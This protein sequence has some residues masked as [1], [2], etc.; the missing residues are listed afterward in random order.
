MCYSGLPGELPQHK[1]CHNMAGLT[2]TIH[3]VE[4]R[5]TIMLEAKCMIIIPVTISMFMHSCLFQ[6]ARNS[7]PQM[8]SASTCLL[9]FALSFYFH[10]ISH[11]EPVTVLLGSGMDNVLQDTYTEGGRRSFKSR[12]T[13][14]LSHLHVERM[15]FVH[16]LD[17]DG[18]ESLCYHL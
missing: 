5:M 12:L 2:S 13:L 7:S 15:I 11:Y 14:S 17:R 10:Q 18:E 16:D 6:G 1:H 9:R 4:E 3:P 8:S